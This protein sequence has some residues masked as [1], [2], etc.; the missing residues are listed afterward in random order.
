MIEPAFPTHRSLNKQDTTETLQPYR[1]PHSLSPLLAS[2]SSSSNSQDPASKFNSSHLSAA[3]KSR[4]KVAGK[5]FETQERGLGLSHVS[6]DHLPP[7]TLPLKLT[8]TSSS[9]IPTIVAVETVLS[10]EEIERKRA[11]KRRRTIRELLE[12]EASYASDMAVVRDIYIA[13]AKGGGKQF[14]FKVT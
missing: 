14:R 1:F 8:R 7:S 12:T 6:Y 2:P 4:T 9:K 11:D 3:L 5:K 10:E 13:R